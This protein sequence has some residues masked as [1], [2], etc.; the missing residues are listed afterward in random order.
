MFYFCACEICNCLEKCF[1]MSSF[2]PLCIFRTFPMYSSCNGPITCNKTIRVLIHERI[3]AIYTELRLRL[4][5]FTLYQSNLFP[6]TNPMHNKLKGKPN[7]KQKRCFSTKL[8]LT[9]YCFSLFSQPISD[10]RIKFGWKE[11]R[12]NC[13]LKLSYFF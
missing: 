9:N 4:F 5:A 6:H 1:D 13:W 8:S 3:T 12:K 2:R 10:G 11:I 7:T